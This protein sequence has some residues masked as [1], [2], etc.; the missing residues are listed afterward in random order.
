MTFLL[1]KTLDDS[2]SYN[3]MQLNETVQ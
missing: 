2:S 3:V 1:I